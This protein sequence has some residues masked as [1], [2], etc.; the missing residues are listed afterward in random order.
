MTTITTFCVLYRFRIRAGAEESFKR[1][2][3]R[4][5]EA[6]RDTRGGLGSR[7]HVAEDGTWYAYAQWPD[8]ETWERA[9]QTGTVADAEAVAMMAAAIE[10]RLP[11]IFLEPQSDLLSPAVALSN[12]RPEHSE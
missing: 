10:E 7:L 1:G 2:W 12:K 9:Q 5:T 8:R 6:I 11:P 3:A 4:V